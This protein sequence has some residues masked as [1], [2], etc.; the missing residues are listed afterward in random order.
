MFHFSAWA[1]PYAP[2]KLNKLLHLGTV[3]YYPRWLAGFFFSSV[4]TAL[5]PCRFIMFNGFLLNLLT[6]WCKTFLSMK[7][8]SYMHGVLISVTQHYFLWNLLIMLVIPAF[9]SLIFHYEK[10][11]SGFLGCY[12]LSK[13]LYGFH[14]VK[15][16]YTSTLL[17][18]CMY[19]SVCLFQNIKYSFRS[20]TSGFT[21]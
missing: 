18:F 12:T 13:H 6:A 10:M 2:I 16:F 21:A 11:S 17:G 19:G 9:I 15:C 4:K 14:L 7:Q 5:F 3:I 8:Y 20:F 1:A